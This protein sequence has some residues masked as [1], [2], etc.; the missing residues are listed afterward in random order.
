MTKEEINACLAILQAEFIPFH[1]VELPKK[2]PNPEE[3]LIGR[4]QLKKKFSKEAWYVIEMFA[5]LPEEFMEVIRPTFNI[6]KLKIFLKE[7][8]GYGRVKSEK[9]IQ[10]IK[11]L[12]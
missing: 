8:K 6:P 11:S 10:E 12:L 9:I 3:I 2:S 4:E 1:E 7:K 5:S